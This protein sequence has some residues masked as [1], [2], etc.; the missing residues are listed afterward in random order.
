MRQSSSKT[1]KISKL[2]STTALTAATVAM[3]SVGGANVARADSGGVWDDWTDIYGNINISFSELMT[4]ITMQGDIYIGSNGSLNIPEGYTVNITGGGAGSLFAAIAAN[5]ADPTVILGNIISSGNVIIMD[6]NGVMFGTNSTVDVNGLIVTTGTIGTDQLI[7]N[8]FGQYTIENV[9]ADANASIDL[10]GT[11]NI[12]EAGLAAFVAPTISNSGVINARL[13]TVVFAAAEAL[14]LDFYGDNLIEILVPSDVQASIENTGAIYAEGGTVVMSAATAEGI[15][16]SIINVSGIIDVSSATM[17]GGNIIL[18]GGNNVDVQV[19]GT[20]DAS[21]AGGGGDIDVRGRDVTITNTAV[22]NADAIGTGDGGSITMIAQNAMDFNGT[23]TARGGDVSGDG[24]FVEVSGLGSIAMSGLV[25]TT[26]LNGATGTLLI[27]PTDLYIDSAWA[28]FIAFLLHFNNVDLLASNSITFTEDLDLSQSWLPF[29]GWLLATHDLSVSAPLVSILGDMIFG[30]G[31][32]SVNADTLNLNGRLYSRA[33]ILGGLDLMDGSRFTT[34]ASLI[35]VMSADALIQQAI[36]FAQ[37]GNGV[38]INVA[39]DTYTENLTIDKDVTLNGNGATLVSADGSEALI[40]V[41][42]SGVTISDFILNGAAGTW[43]DYGI[44]ALNDAMNGLNI[45]GNT[46]RNFSEAGIYLGTTALSG[47]SSGLSAPVNI[48]GNVFE[49]SAT[50]GLVVDG[51]ISGTVLNISNNEFGSAGDELLN[52]IMFGNISASTINI[53]GN[54]MSTTGIGLGFGNLK[55]TTINIFNND[56]V[57]GLDAIHMGGNM[58]YA[59]INILNNTRIQSINGNAIY[60][61]DRVPGGGNRLTISGN[62]N[63]SAGQ[64]GIY[65]ANMAGTTISDN[66]ILSAGQN[67]IVLAFSDNSTISGNHVG[68]TTLDGIQVTGSDDINISENYLYNIGDDGIHISGSDDAS[69]TRNIIH[70][71]GGNGIYVDGGSNV[72]IRLNH[73]H[74]VGSDG[75]NVNNNDNAY[76]WANYVG[77]AGDNGIEVSGSNNAY[78]GFN[79]IWNS[80]NNGID[81][82][83][84]NN[85]Q[86]VSN[87]IRFTGNDGIRASGSNDVNLSLN[88]I[89]F[90][91]GDGIDVTSSLRANIAGNQIGHV[92]GAGISV[93]NSSFAN[94]DDN[95]IH[96][97]GSYGVNVRYSDGVSITN[98]LVEETGDDSIFAMFSDTL[99]ILNNILRGSDADGIDVENSSGVTIDGNDISDIAHNGIELERTK[100][101]SITNNTVMNAGLNGIYLDDGLNTVINGNVI[102]LVGQNGINVINSELITIS[103]NTVSDAE[104]AGIY[105]GGSGDISVLGNILTN[106]TFGISFADVT[107]SLIEENKITGSLD[108]GILLDGVDGLEIL[109]NDITGS[110]VHGLYAMGTDNGSI[111]MLGNIFTDNTVGASFESGDIDISDLTNP[112]TFIG[113]DVAMRFSGA[114]VSLVGNTIGSTIFSGQS[115]YYVEFL[116]GAFFN[117]GTPTIIDGRFASYDGFVPMSGAVALD[118]DGNPILTAAQLQAIEDMLFDFDDTGLIGQIFTGLIPA[119]SIEDQFDEFDADEAAASG[120]NLTVR[121]LP[122]VTFGGG[123]AALAGIAPA[124]GGEQTAEILA[125]ITP[126]AGEESPQNVA[127]IEPE[128]GGETDECLGSALTKASQGQVTTYNFSGVFEDTLASTA[129]CAQNI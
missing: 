11:I 7:N 16:D 63:I 30:T 18:S 37:N 14:T 105:V 79:S 107:D 24:G 123:A 61:V 80:G 78:I 70:T 36:D 121:G 65:V 114:D 67:G 12:A 69:I 92:D 17:Q 110:G 126:A 112:N 124:A 83:A 21:G 86:I 76:I 26:A 125:A 116:N 97:T 119:L 99:S 96:D 91:G 127:E 100:G 120:F 118:G 74:N 108:T 40:T 5:G 25:D 111:V 62:Q 102:S 23:A 48:A 22:L 87:Y 46:F 1:N 85:V 45:I 93:M 60:V 84:S 82:E 15:V 58:D 43:S 28:E 128:A 89:A 27:D 88:N 59:E 117:P 98:N 32:F 77:G 4:L 75:I 52:A 13:G 20:L 10:H 9:G 2:L 122:Q 64:D 54:N 71:A 95:D 129:N 104:E 39:N 57:A 38:T 66:E 35:N 19:S 42:Q 3:L 103:E 53:G 8:E 113:G 68:N 34:N 94:I 41:T 49:G 33:A 56:I 72:N 109:N 115:T 31:N 50:R 29:I 51:L 44:V 55:R 106:N 81:L 73:V 6:Q 90:A 101:T 47:A